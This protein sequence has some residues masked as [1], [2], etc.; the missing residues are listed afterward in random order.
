M[1]TARAILD[2]FPEGPVPVQI[3][4]VEHTGHVR[5]WVARPTPEGQ[6]LEG[7]IRYPFLR[8]V[9]GGRQ[10]PLANAY[11]DEVG[12]VAGRYGLLQRDPDGQPALL[13]NNDPRPSRWRLLLGRWNLAIHGPQPPASPDS[14]K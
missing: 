6:H 2:A 7:R 14:W 4:R 9:V 3:L 10:R 13:V 1:P 12:V 8:Q 11:F 5:F